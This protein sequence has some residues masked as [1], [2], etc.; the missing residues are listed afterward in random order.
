[1]ETNG[2]SPSLDDVRALLQ[3][4][5]KRPVLLYI[6]AREKGPRYPGWQDVTFEQTQSVKYQRLLIAHPNTGVLLGIDNLCTIDCDTDPSAKPCSRSAR[7]FKT[8]CAPAA[9]AAVSSGSI[10]REPAQTKFTRSRSL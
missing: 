10:L 2:E 1:V 8:P 7:N 5:G 4:N 3:R 9:P 6:P